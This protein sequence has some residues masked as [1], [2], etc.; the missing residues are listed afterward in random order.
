MN[1]AQHDLN[2][3]DWAVKLQSN[4][5]NEKPLLL[6]I[7]VLKFEQICFLAVDVSKTIINEQ[8]TE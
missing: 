5:N 6:T 4:Q 8:R 7:L 1:L 3:V 2:S